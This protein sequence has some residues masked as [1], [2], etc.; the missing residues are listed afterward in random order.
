MRGRRKRGNRQTDYVYTVTLAAHARRGLIS[1]AGDSHG[2]GV[3]GV[4]GEPEVVKSEI[5]CTN[6][7]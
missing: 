2:G 7:I 4:T 3:S 6:Y 5:L 1:T